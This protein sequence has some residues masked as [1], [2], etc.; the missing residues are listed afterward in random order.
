MQLHRN[1][2]FDNFEEFRAH[3]RMFRFE[4]A[5]NNFF[6]NMT[7]KY[8]DNQAKQDKQVYFEKYNK[9]IPI[10]QLSTGEK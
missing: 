1:G 6:D 9:S 10:D 7:F 3:S 5:F 2:E 8:V 4:N